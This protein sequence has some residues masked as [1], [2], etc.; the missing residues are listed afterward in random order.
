[1]EYVMAGLGLGVRGVRGVVVL[2]FFLGGGEG[3]GEREDEGEGEARAVDVERRVDRRV[4][5]MVAARS[6]GACTHRLTSPVATP[7]RACLRT[8]SP[9]FP[10]TR[11]TPD[12]HSNASTRSTRRPSALPATRRHSP[13]APTMSMRAALTAHATLLATQY[14]THLPNILE[15]QTVF[16]HDI[17]PA[18]ADELDLDAPAQAA[19]RAWLQDTITLFHIARRNQWTRS[20]AMDAVRKTLVWRLENVPV[21]DQH[22]SLP[23]AT[24]EH[25][26]YTPP[27]HLLP[28]AD[29]AGR[30]VLV[31]KLRDLPPRAHRGAVIRALERLRSHLCRLNHER[32]EGPGSP[33]SPL[34]AAPSTSKAYFPSSLQSSSSPHT[35]TSL[36]IH[37]TPALQYLLLLD[38]SSASLPSLDLDLITWTL[39]DASPKFPGL[40]A[41]VL[42]LNYSWAH[43]GL[44]GVAKRLIP[45]AG[46]GGRVWFP[47][48]EELVDW[49]GEG[50]LPE[51]YGGTLKWPLPSPSR[52]ASPTPST[53]S[54]FSS[55][56]AAT[57]RTPSPSP[58]LNPPIPRAISLS[59]LS[60][61][62]PFF[63]Y[64]ARSH[65]HAPASHNSLRSGH[66]TLPA[67]LRTDALH[68]RRHSHFLPHGRRRR[69]DLAK[70]LL[71]LFWA[72]WGGVIRAVVWCVALGWAGRRWKQLLVGRGG[73]GWGAGRGGAGWGAERG[74]GIGGVVGKGGGR[75]SAKEKGG[76][77]SKE[78]GGRITRKEWDA[79]LA[80]AFTG[81]GA[82]GV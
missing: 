44:W 54:T 36:D 55:H 48:T 21:A 62:N 63:G 72:R 59:P 40:V 32:P 14:T 16:L 17:L 49:F 33:S 71:L 34:T 75:I 51:E 77:V 38:L 81:F 18:L 15:L 69:R 30:P 23:P 68:H 25:D 76:I 26:T 45:E 29:P 7:D 2:R 19:A 78:K 80:L 41:G 42:V 57:S 1:M 67:H 39:R 27:P 20:C 6:T 56:T 60:I 52:P 47:T 64:P 5:A 37:S 70:T 10:I 24:Y 46:S 66:P 58:S 65:S 11:F 13:D 82:A 35:S 9:S 28:H 12:A 61:L 22:S 50:N 4:L 79:L 3:G 43:A 53:T 74:G 8:R 31:L 73:A